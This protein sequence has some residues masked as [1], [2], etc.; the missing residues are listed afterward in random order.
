MTSNA[1]MNTYG[2]R[3]LTLVKGDGAYVWDDQGKKYLDALAGIAVCGLGHAH[4][5][6]TAAVADQA[7][8]LVHCSNLYNIPAQEALADKL[9]ALSGMSNMFFSNSGAEANEAAIKIARLHGHA[10]GVE[11]PTIIVTDQAFHGRTLATLTA[12]GNRKVHAGFEPLVRGFSRAPF[13][14]IDAIQAIGENNPNIVAVLVEPIQG[15]G[16][17]NIPAPD[18]LQQL[19]ALC[20]T[21]GW[22]LMLDEIQTA[23][24]RTGTFF[25]Y[26]QHNI[27]PDVVTIAKGLGNGVPIGACLTH[28]PAAQLMQPGNHGSTFGGNPIACAAALAT[29]ETIESEN[30]T[31]RASALGAHLLQAFS[32]A[33][34]D[35]DKVK[36]IRGSGLMI[37][38]ELSEPCAE[39]VA[40][41]ADK[42][43]LINVTAGNVIRLL[44]ALNLSDEQAEQLVDI[45]VPLINAF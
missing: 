2:Q 40:K 28:G 20:D 16:G 45:L 44:P 36:D 30:L 21:K 11:L 34:A 23:N 39:L 12:T 7:Q 27:L 5:A 14:D 10:K 4:P 38:I 3:A 41:A 24:G 8:T 35:C 29:L 25:H 15:E 19:R 1:L 17:I 6:V 18:Y 33:L 42:G 22:L 9:S 31:Q 37:G 26:Q 43:L 13:N 32:T